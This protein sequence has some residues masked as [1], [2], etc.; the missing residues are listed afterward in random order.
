MKKTLFYISISLIFC[1]LAKSQDVF[2]QFGKASF[3]ADK[4]EGRSTASGE[5]YSHTKLTAAHLT[6][7][8]GTKVK[9]TNL[10]NK[11]T[12]IVRINDRGPFVQGRIIDLSKAAAMKLDFI[13]AGVAE[14]KIEVIDE[15]NPPNDYKPEDKEDVP[16]IVPVEEEQKEFY[17]FHATKAEPSGFGV[18]ISSFREIANLMR[19]SETLKTR[20]SENVIIQVAYINKVKVYR[21]IIGSY[22]TRQEAKKVMQ[23]LKP[24]YRDCFV[25]DFRF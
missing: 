24:E 2:I 25:V 14:V 15:N 16:R 18:Q 17:H 9:V 6:L 11:K 1:V 23:K 4:F 20:Y 13:K 7:P 12:A 10:S 22:N 19:I 8:F 21:V 5:K 3:Y